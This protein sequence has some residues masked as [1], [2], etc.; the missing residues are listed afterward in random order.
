MAPVL[1][2]I[3]DQMMEPKWVISMGV[4]ASSGGMFNNYAIVQGVDQIVPVDVYAPGCPPSPETL[5]HAILTLHDK[6]KNGELTRRDGEGAGLIV[7][8]MG[9][10][11]P[12]PVTLGQG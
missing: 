9:P 6:I 4:C 3:Y 11:G 12:V 5:M 7:E 1:R 10:S 2:Q 8:Q